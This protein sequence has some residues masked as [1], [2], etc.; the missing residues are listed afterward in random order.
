MRRVEKAEAKYADC[1]NIVPASVT[2][3][4]R[5]VEHLAGVGAGVGIRVDS[6]GVF[7]GS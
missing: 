4:P 7:D 2:L 6:V 1:A 3:K 5:R